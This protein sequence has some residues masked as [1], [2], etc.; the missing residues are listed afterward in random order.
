[1][2]SPIAG[3]SSAINFPI[4]GHKIPYNLY[5]TWHAYCGRYREKLQQALAGKLLQVNAIT[6][7]FIVG[8]FEYALSF[9][10]FPTSSAPPENY[11][12]KRPI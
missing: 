2:V 4:R 3:R 1:L 5:V 12:F 6:R 8:I 11:D 9:F 10:N 7:A